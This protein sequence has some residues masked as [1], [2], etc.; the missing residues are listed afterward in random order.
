MW[1]PPTPTHH[2]TTYTTQRTPH[3]QGGVG[4]HARRRTCRGAEPI[5]RGRTPHTGRG[6]AH[7][8]PAWLGCGWH[9]A[10]AQPRMERLWLHRSVPLHGTPLP[11]CASVHMCIMGPTETR[12]FTQSR[13]ARSAFLPMTPS[14]AAVGQVF[15]CTRSLRHESRERSCDQVGRSVWFVDARPAAPLAAAAPTK[16]GRLFHAQMD[17]AGT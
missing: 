7:A 2:H 12:N 8:R 9:A 1:V 13:A 3:A 5:P 6:R 14:R 11:F 16:N 10:V 15:A 17:Q 4:G